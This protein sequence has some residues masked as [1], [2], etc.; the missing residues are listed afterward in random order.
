MLTHFEPEHL[1]APSQQ[2]G[3]R[4]PHRHAYAHSLTVCVGG[5]L[6][7][8]FSYEHTVPPCD[9]DRWWHEPVPRGAEHL[10]GDNDWL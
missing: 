5:A 6:E 10:L 4:P 3:R 9:V 1:H 2:H 7:A 8:A